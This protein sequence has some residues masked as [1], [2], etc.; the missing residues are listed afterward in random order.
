LVY[1][2]AVL[3]IGPTVCIFVNSIIRWGHGGLT[4]YRNE[5]MMF[6]YQPL[7]L[8]PI[9]PQQND[10]S[11]CDGGTHQVS[12]VHL[13]GEYQ[14][15][16]PGIK[17]WGIGVIIPSMAFLSCVRV[18]WAHSFRS[19]HWRWWPLSL[20]FPCKFPGSVDDRSRWNPRRDRMSTAVV[21]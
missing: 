8:W 9:K 18:R 12:R 19:P 2:R 3:A 15:Y 21:D 7:A 10:P 16:G 5:N 13:G 20:G 14:P 6:T 1:E 11:I 4:R 17:L